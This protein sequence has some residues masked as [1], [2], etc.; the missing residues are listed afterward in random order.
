MITVAPRCLAS[1][2]A[3]PATPP[4]AALDQDGFAGFELSRVFEGPERGQA[5]QRHRRRLGMAEPVGLLG[6]DRGLDRDLF[7]VAALDPL[8]GD[9]EHRVADGKIGDAGAERADDA[10]EV[11]A[12]DIGE[13]QVV[14]GT[15]QAAPCSRRH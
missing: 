12:Q 6:D 3:K 2:I 14:A 13:L 11:A 5:G 1:W 9:A 7:G 8:V 15:A 4:G 10:G